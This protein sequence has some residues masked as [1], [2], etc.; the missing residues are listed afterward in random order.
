M[1]DEL[2]TMVGEFYP[3]A[4]QSMGFDKDASI[5]FQDDANNAADILGKT[6]YYD[7]STMTVTLYVTNRHPKDILRSLAHELVHHAQN[8]RGDLE[9]IQATGEGYAQ[10]DKHAREMER[11]AYEKGNLVFRDFEDKTKTERKTTI[12]KQKESVMEH[13]DKLRDSLNQELMRRWGYDKKSDSSEQE[14]EKQ[15]KTDKNDSKE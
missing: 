8:C 13:L 4:Q 3:Y 1:D 7:P 2:K 12:K 5:E 6:A 15:E 10:K 11:E 14:K 9:S